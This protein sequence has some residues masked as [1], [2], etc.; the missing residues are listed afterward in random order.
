LLEANFD[1][2]GH[3]LAIAISPSSRLLAIGRTTGFEI[4]D[5]AT[6]RRVTHRGSQSCVPAFEPDGDLLM[7]C[8]A[9]LYRWPLQESGP[10]IDQSQQ[11]EI[12]RFGPPE[13]LSGP[14]ADYILSTSQDGSLAVVRTHEGWQLLSLDHQRGAVAVPC[15]KDT[16]GA[17][18]SPNNA[19]LALTNWGE[20]GVSIWDTSTSRQIVELPAGCFGKPLFSP[21]GRWLATT[22]DGVRLWHTA[23]WQPGPRFHA[24]GQTLGGLAFAFSP[25]SRVLAIS[26][27]EEITR[28]VDPETG[29][30]WAELARSDLRNSPYIAFSPDHAR[31]IE[32]PGGRGS[33]RIWDLAGIRAEL[34]Q[35][36]LDWPDDVLAI[37]PLPQSGTSLWDRTLA[38]QETSDEPGCGT[39]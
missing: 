2:P 27:P 3:A 14:L 23:G 39:D 28:L 35:R 8:T 20:D 33:P 37:R 6:C 13:P 22:P 12:F 25:D 17:A 26:Q 15:C 4:W 30:D 5:L 38:L 16:R 1:S 34:K 36:D 19:W 18:L 29:R 31:F 10:T 24:Q 7:G 9:G 32:V 11:R 21:D